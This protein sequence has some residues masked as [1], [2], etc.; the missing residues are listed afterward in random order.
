MLLGKVT[1]SRHILHP[2]DV[3]G[4]MNTFRCVKFY[5]RRK[6]VPLGEVRCLS[7]H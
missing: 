4:Y 2:N 3:F 7:L 5:K 1:Q 6:V